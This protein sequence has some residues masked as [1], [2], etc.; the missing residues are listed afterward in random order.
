MSEG[1]VEQPIA[2]AAIITFSDQLRAFYWLAPHSIRIVAVGVAIMLCL[3]LIAAPGA[4][5]GDLYFSPP[6]LIGLALVFWIAIMAF[7]Y[8][9]LSGA[10][11]QVTYLVTREQ[12]ETRDAADAAIIVP[13][14]G[15]KRC[16]ESRSGFALRLKPA[17]LRWLPKRAF[18]S[19]ATLALR[20][21]I[22][23]KLGAR[24][25]LRP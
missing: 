8:R 15:V 7:G 10:Q 5:G 4:D 23:D 2:G 25:R 24:A 18:G 14:N 3:E 21:L 11:R 22:A 20:R 9:R 17:G 13:W 16:F 12:I 6:V 1:S 19:D